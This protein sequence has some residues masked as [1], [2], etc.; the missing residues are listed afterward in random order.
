MRAIVEAK[1]AQAQTEKA[2]WEQRLGQ[3]QQELAFAGEQFARW[4]GV[5]TAC[6]EMLTED[7]KPGADA[8]GT[9]NGG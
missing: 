2:A 7:G 6:N 1:L 3:L 9:P 4:N 5:I 8:T